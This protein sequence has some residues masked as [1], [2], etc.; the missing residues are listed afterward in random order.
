M[1]D[2]QAEHA[3][4]I[5]QRQCAGVE[6]TGLERIALQEL[7]DRMDAPERTGCIAAIIRIMVD[8]E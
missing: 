5:F 3:A 4:Q 6:M 1:N 8:G 7:L 2:L